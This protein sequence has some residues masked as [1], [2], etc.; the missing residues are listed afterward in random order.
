MLQKVWPRLFSDPSVPNSDTLFVLLAQW[1]IET[2]GGASMHCWNVGNIKGRIGG[3]DGHSWTLFTCNEFLTAKQ[4]RSIASKAKPRTDGKP[5]LDVTVGGTNSKGKIEVFLHPSHP[6]ACFRAYDSLEE[7]VL[8]Y[9]HEL[10]TRFSEAWPAALTGDPAAFSKKLSLRYYTAPES[11]YTKA[12]T[13]RFNQL[14]KHHDSVSYKEAQQ[15]RIMAALES[16]G[17]DMYPSYDA[18]VRRFQ[19]DQGLNDDG[20]VGPLTERKLQEALAGKG[21]GSSGP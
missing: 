11:A 6:G 20:D 1:S 16:L 10:H 21:V 3:G 9:L 15:M 8:D 14:K 7:G 4:A 17:Y 13:D 12:L 18:V 19:K 2:G 5:G